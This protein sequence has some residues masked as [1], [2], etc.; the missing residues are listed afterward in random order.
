MQFF[1]FNFKEV[2]FA[3]CS[4]LGL[5]WLLSFPQINQPRALA[6]L[7]PLIPAGLLSAQNNYP[8]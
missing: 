3:A 7:N 5:V 4:I 6:I 1:R 2:K 8:H